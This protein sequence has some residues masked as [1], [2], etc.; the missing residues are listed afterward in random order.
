[1]YAIT[2]N[3]AVAVANRI[4]AHETASDLTYGQVGFLGVSVQALDPA[5]AS[6]LG[7]N[8]NSGALVINVQS[9]SPA[10]NG[11]LTRGS[12]ITRVGGSTVTSAD[13]LGTAIRAH[14]PGESVSVTFVNSSGS[15]T[16]TVTL[17]G[18][19]P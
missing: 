12:V 17:A 1:G 11:G 16:V 19:N 15:R 4:R 2:A 3:D 13:S 10:D 8:A 14:K 9:D 18:V 7:I 5:T 6:R